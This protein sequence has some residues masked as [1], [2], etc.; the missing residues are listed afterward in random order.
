MSLNLEV[1]S[2]EWP[3]KKLHA[4]VSFS[5]ITK[6]KLFVMHMIKYL[7]K[8]SESCMKQFDCGNQEFSDRAEICDENRWVSGRIS[9]M[10]KIKKTIKETDSWI[11]GAFSHSDVTPSL[12]RRYL[13][14]AG[15]PPTKTDP[16][17]RIVKVI[18]GSTTREWGS[19]TVKERKPPR[20]K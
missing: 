14:Q 19:E 8:W 13:S 18:P 1:S 2:Q 3:F 10:A 6:L 7:Q 15:I 4:T 20:V 17:A 11:R 9:S 12:A 5:R 16:E